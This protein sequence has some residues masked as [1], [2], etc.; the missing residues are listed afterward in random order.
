MDAYRDALA[1]LC[2]AARVESLVKY[3]DPAAVRL[4]GAAA[5]A[6][7]E[8]RTRAT[9]VPTCNYDDTSPPRTRE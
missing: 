5:D 4:I 3:L 7:S 6:A 1:A 8:R 2:E 9:S